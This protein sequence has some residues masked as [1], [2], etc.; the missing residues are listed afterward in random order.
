MMILE[1]NSRPVKSDRRLEIDI[2]AY[3]KRSDTIVF[4]EV[5]QHKYKSPYQLRLRSINK[6][7]LRNLYRA[8]TS[9]RVANSYFGPV[10]FDVIE[11]Y[12]ER[13]LQPEIDHI[14]NINLFVK[15]DRFVNWQGD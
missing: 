15:P 12:G 5:K 4:I 11:I 3:D 2:I 10:R 9:W 8:C 6:R 7:K 13:G 14:T 1:R